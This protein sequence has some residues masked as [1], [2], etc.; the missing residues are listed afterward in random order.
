M[1]N[2]DPDDGLTVLA[3][4]DRHLRQHSES[5]QE[6]LTKNEAVCCDDKIIEHRRRL[7]QFEKEYRESVAPQP[8][9]IKVL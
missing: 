4:R 8:G 1:S 2:F 3:I 5:L 7:R 9:W 6:D